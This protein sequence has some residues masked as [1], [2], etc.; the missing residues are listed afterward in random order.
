MPKEKQFNCL[1]NPS[2]HYE[3]FGSKQ[4][5][6]MWEDSI[7]IAQGLKLIKDQLF[8]WESEHISVGGSSASERYF[9]WYN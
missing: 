7:H 2:S 5:K 6:M 4:S 8:K 3:Y 9:T 1:V